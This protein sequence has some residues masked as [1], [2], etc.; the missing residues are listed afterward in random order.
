MKFHVRTDGADKGFWVLL[1]NC[2]LIALE[3]LEDWTLGGLLR[4][5]AIKRRQIGAVLHFM[6]TLLIQAKSKNLQIWFAKTR[7]GH[8]CVHWLPSLEKLIEK[9][10]DNGPHDKF[11]MFMSSSPTPKLLSNTNVPEDCL[12]WQVISTCRLF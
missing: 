8:L 11:R 6:V 9:T 4:F 2:I 5:V 3:S 12:G 1:A 7:P 10:F